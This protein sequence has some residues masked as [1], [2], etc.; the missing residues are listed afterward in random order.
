MDTK[1]EYCDGFYDD[2]MENCPHCGAT[3]K[4]IR[5]VSDQIPKTIDELKQYCINNNVPVQQMHFYIG[6]DYK[7]PK[8]FGIFRNGEQVVVYK[9]KSDGSRAIRYAGKDEAYAVN[10]I[11]QKMRSE[12]ANHKAANVNRIRPSTPPPRSAKKKGINPG[13]IIL[14]CVGLFI[15]ICIGYALGQPSTGYYTYNGNQYYNQRGDWYMFDDDTDDWI[16]SYQPEDKMD[17]YFDSSYY[18]SDIDGYDFSDSAFYTEPSYNSDSDSYS[19]NSWNNNNNWNSWNSGS[20][21]NW[22]SGSDWNSNW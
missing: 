19:S 2:Q 5:R 11:Y 3:N 12:Y 15:L 21:W 16:P 4:H 17:D 20:D 18:S 6:E 13:V 8:A 22:N 14:I 1:C 9:N 10:E 7:G